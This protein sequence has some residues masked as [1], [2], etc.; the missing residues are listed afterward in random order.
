MAATQSTAAATRARLPK[1]HHEREVDHVEARQQRAPPLL[2]AR[3]ADG[4]HAHR[5]RGGDRRAGPPQ[6]EDGTTPRTGGGGWGPAGP[7]GRRPGWA[8]PAGAPP[9]GKRRGLGGGDSAAVG[10]GGDPVT[11][12]AFC[13]VLKLVD[14]PEVNTLAA[15]VR[16][17]LERVMAAL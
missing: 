8:Q 5:G 6:R 9:G 16:S 11:G 7:A 17:R 15:E 14:R 1:I 4:G 3:A 10:I 12:S 13:D 2:G